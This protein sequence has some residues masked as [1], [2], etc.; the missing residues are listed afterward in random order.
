MIFVCD[1]SNLFHN[2]FLGG[3]Y[4]TSEIVLDSIV[5]EA[6]NKDTSESSSVQV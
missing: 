1:K 6:V 4:G 2:F 5:V 3:I